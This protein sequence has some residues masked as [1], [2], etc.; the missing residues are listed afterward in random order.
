MSVLAA[1]F[2]QSPTERRRYV[3]DYTLFLAPGENI[4]GVT[5]V[6]TQITGATSPAFVVDSIALLPTVGGVTYGAAYFADGGVDAGIYEV[7]FLATTSLGQ[8]LEDV[9]LYTLQAKV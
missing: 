2:S 1:K 6:V 3:L 9:V 4:I 8:T 7:Q 5:A